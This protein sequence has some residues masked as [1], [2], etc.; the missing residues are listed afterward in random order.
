MDSYYKALSFRDL[1]GMSDKRGLRRGAL[2][3]R[4]DLTDDEFRGLYD[5]SMDFGMVLRNR[6]LGLLGLSVYGES[7]VLLLRLDKL[8]KE[9][10]ISQVD[11]CRDLGITRQQYH[12]YRSGFN[13]VPADFLFGMV[14]YL[15]MDLHLFD[16]FNVDLGSVLDKGR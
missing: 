16:G 1:V 6:F 5:G 3:R 15:S 13:R 7:H 9:R 12:H 11:M 10:K 8:R 14:R 4:L 2:A